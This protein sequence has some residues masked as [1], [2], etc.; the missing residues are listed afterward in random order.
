MHFVKFLTHC[1]HAWQL[2]ERIRQKIA[3]QPEITA[4]KLSELLNITELTI[5]LAIAYLSTS[6]EIFAVGVEGVEKN[7]DKILSLK[8]VSREYLLD[9][10]AKKERAKVEKERVKEHIR[11]ELT[12]EEI[13]IPA[14]ARKLGE[15]E[16][17]VQEAIADLEDAGE[18]T[19]GRQVPDPRAPNHRYITYA[20]SKTAQTAIN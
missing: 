1:H 2:K 12:E 8:Y 17:I 5:F 13:T 19:L 14:L 6:G 11:Q 20:K 16:Q 3:E 7:G 15:D 4:P 9:E 10:E 18:I